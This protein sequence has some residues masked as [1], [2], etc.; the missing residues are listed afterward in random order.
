VRVSRNLRRCGCGIDRVGN[1]RTCAVASTSAANRTDRDKRRLRALVDEADAGCPSAANE[2]C[3]TRC[4]SNPTRVTAYLPTSPPTRAT[5]GRSRAPCATGR[6]AQLVATWAN[7]A[8]QLPIACGT[9]SGWSDKEAHPATTLARTRH[10]GCSE[11][12]AR[13]PGGLPS[14]SRVK[15]GLFGAHEIASA[16]REIGDSAEI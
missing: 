5:G 11:R 10:H 7:L 9:V 13:M 15:I 12:L 8:G 16:C 6:P 14:L 4:T 3:T 2:R 1:Q